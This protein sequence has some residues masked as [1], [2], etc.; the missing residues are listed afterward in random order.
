MQPHVRKGS[1]LP[2]IF[3]F[4]IRKARK[5]SVVPP[6]RRSGITTKARR[7]QSRCKRRKMFRQNLSVAQP[8][9]KVPWRSFKNY[10]WSKT[11]RFHQFDGLRTGVVDKRKSVFATEPDIDIPALRIL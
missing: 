3:V 5:S 8:C 7:K 2:S 11:F 9:L 1:I 6:I 10:C 4:A